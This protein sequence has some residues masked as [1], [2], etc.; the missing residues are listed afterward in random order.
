VAPGPTPQRPL[1]Q[2]LVPSSPGATTQVHKAFRF[3]NWGSV[4]AQIHVHGGDSH[5]HALQALQRD[6]SGDGERKCH[7]QRREPRGDAGSAT[8][9]PAL[10]NG[11]AVTIDTAHTVPYQQS[12]AEHR[13]DM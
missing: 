1:P 7:H 12:T 3:D 8:L 11:M 2:P 4:G 5:G 13:P 10:V 6:Q 9:T